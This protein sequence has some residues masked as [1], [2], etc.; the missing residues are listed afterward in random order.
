VQQCVLP[1][2]VE[3]NTR[4]DIRAYLQAQ[5]GLVP[6]STAAATF[7]PCN[8]QPGVPV[9]PGLTCDVGPGGVSFTPFRLL[10]TVEGSVNLC[11]RRYENFFFQTA[12]CLRINPNKARAVAGCAP[13]AQST[14]S[15]Q[16][17]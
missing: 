7:N 4:A 3:F 2:D 9:I 14:R 10:S 11:S 13:A 5:V 1:S 17:V 8:Y 16:I 12:G 6:I 15:Q